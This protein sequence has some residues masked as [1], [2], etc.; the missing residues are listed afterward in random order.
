MDEERERESGG[1]GSAAAAAPPSAVARSQ[2]YAALEAAATPEALRAL[3]LAA[4]PAHLAS[5]D[6]LRAKELAVTKLCGLYVAAGDTASL[7]GLLAFLRPFFAQVPKART[8]KIVRG[9]LEALSRIPGS[10]EVQV[11][12]CLETVEWCKAEKR[13]FLRLR[14]QLRL[15]QL[16][17]Q[18]RPADRPAPTPPGLSLCPFPLPLPHFS[19]HPPPHPPPILLQAAGPGQAAAGAGHHHGAA[20][21]GQAPG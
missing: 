20:A 9:I 6:D 18:R 2:L 3:V 16:C 5:D 4:V 8:A 10:T 14:V 19:Y 21:R 12:V 1:G 11:A 15:S 7:S 13:S 17:V